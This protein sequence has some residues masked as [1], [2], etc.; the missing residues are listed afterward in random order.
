M[1]HCAYMDLTQKQPGCLEY[2]KCISV[3]FHWQ[4]LFNRE[5]LTDLMDQS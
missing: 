5:Q 2:F 3:Q 1:R 4:I